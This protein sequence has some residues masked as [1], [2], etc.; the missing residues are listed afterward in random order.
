MRAAICKIAV[1]ALPGPN[2]MLQKLQV[3]RQQA[4]HGVITLILLLRGRSRSLAGKAA[5][6]AS[7]AKW[8][9]RPTA[10]T[11][12]RIGTVEV[13]AR[14]W[15]AGILM[16]GLYQRFRSVPVLKLGM[17]RAERQRK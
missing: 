11:L 6:E 8:I 3:K 12:N 17:M 13:A 1:S 2:P 10:A 4:S 14:T 16:G 9:T 15:P 7:L 5:L